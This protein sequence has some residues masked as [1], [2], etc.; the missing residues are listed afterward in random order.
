MNDAKKIEEQA[1]YEVNEPITK[2]FKLPQG[3]ACGKGTK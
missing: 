1:G 3:L 2:I